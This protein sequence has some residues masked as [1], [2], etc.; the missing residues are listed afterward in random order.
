M[1]THFMKKAKNKDEAAKEAEVP[2]PIRNKLKKE[3]TK[4]DGIYKKWLESQSP[5][6]EKKE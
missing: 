6:E 3:W 4:Q 1:P 2:E 5:T